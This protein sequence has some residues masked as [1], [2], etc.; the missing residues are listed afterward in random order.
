MLVFLATNKKKAKK[1]MKR[2][3]D[4]G[5][6]DIHWWW[7][8]QTMPINIDKSSIVNTNDT[9]EFYSKTGEFLTNQPWK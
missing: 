2:N 6:A 5:D 1:F 3:S 9:L 8:L 4:Y 7:C